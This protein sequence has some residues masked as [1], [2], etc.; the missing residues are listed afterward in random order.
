MNYELVVKYS[1]IK[2]VLV[3][4]TLTKFIGLIVVDRYV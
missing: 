4:V 2:L 1:S 3:C